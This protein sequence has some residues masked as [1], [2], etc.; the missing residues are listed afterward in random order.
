M[1]VE[2]LHIFRQRLIILHLY[3]E[4]VIGA[5]FLKMKNEVAVK[6]FLVLKQNIL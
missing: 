1:S 5:V 6:V 3:V 4:S 2:A